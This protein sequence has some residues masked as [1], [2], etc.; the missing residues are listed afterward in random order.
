MTMSVAIVVNP[1]KIGSAARARELINT[2]A[3]SVGQE[4]P[5]WFETTAEDPGPGQARRAV[6]QGATTVLAWG[7]DGTLM[8]VASTLVK[9]D[10]SDVSVGIVPGGTGNLLARNLGVPLDTRKAIEVALTGDVRR[11]DL[12]DVYLGQ[13]ERALSAVMCGI[14]WDADMMG[15]PEA[16][17]RTVGWGAYVVEGA[18]SIGRKQM[19]LRLSVDGGP[20]EHLYGRTVLVANVGMLVAGIDLIP[21]AE[22]DDGLL[23]VLVVDPSSPLDWARTTVG[24][25]RG[26]GA[27]DD[28]SRTHLRGREVIVSTSRPRG[29]QV[30]GDTVSDGHGFR[31]A[32]LPKALAVRVPSA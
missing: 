31:V 25:L 32:L 11:I 15:A 4:P 19:R 12:L 6:E 24:V 29:R 14:G 16:L 5:A 2:V 23:D 18:R 13:G 9:S 21:E 20:Q 22:A 8:G 17:K 10:V 28:P 3:T 27:E 30:D 26:K 1:M 7:G